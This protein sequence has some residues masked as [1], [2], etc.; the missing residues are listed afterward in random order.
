M[1][2]PASKEFAAAALLRG[3]F[4]TGEKAIHLSDKHRQPLGAGFG[5]TE[6]RERVSCRQN[7]VGVHSGLAV[8]SVPD[9]R[10]QVEQDRL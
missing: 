4:A 2:L 5:I 7:A 3:R 10:R 6:R 8:Q 9:Q 1:T